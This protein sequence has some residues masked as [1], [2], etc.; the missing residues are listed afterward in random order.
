MKLTDSSYTHGVFLE[1]QWIYCPLSGIYIFQYICIEQTGH[2]EV[3]EKEREPC[4]S[5]TFYWLFVMPFFTRDRD[6]EITEQEFD[7]D[8]EMDMRYEP[9]SDKNKDEPGSVDNEPDSDKDKDLWFG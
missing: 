5:T 3:R 1:H 7:T 6:D 9:S 8:S 4:Q 2:R